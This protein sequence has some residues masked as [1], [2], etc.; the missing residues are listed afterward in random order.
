MEILNDKYYIPNIEDIRYGYEYEELWENI[1]SIKEKLIQEWKPTIF[2]HSQ[3]VYEY[4]RIRQIITGVHFSFESCGNLVRRD[5]I[6]VPFL[7][8][9]QIEAEGWRE[10]KLNNNEQA[11]SL[12]KKNGYD[13]RIYQDCLRLSELMVG[14]GM[15][16]SWDK[17]LFEGECKSI[18]E[19]R[20]ICKWLKI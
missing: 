12:Y 16:P 13:L 5:K 3:D 15:M 1:P 11:T 7:T 4:N 8:K 20:L 10:V 2:G 19:F 9:E 17:I 18:N 14:A 6:R